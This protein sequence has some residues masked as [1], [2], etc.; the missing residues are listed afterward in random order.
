MNL[1]RLKMLAATND[2]IFID[3]EFIV[4][5]FKP[6]KFTSRFHAHTREVLAA[7]IAPFEDNILKAG[8]LFRCLNI[9]LEI[10]HLTADRTVDAMRAHKNT[11]LKI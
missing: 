2:A 7:T 4:A 3:V 5:I 11:A 1:M 6:N 9:R 10:I 8:K